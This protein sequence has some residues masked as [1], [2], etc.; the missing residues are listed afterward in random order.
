MKQYNKYLIHPA[1]R[2]DQENFSSVIDEVQSILEKTN[3]FP[4]SFKSEIILSFLKNHTIQ[5]NWI[6]AN[7][8]LTEL[9]TSGTLFTGS[10]ESLFK[11]CDNR[12]AFRQDLENYLKD[13]FT[14]TLSLETT[15][16]K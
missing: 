1:D 9:V 11:S 10:I 4:S 8:G 13:I 15:V 7:P 6:E 16:K 14:K 2:F 12:L 3:T 5:D